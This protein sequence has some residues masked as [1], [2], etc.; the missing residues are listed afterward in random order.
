MEAVWFVL[1]M[2]G[3][4]YGLFAAAWL[5]VLVSTDAFG[6]GGLRPR[7][8]LWIGLLTALFW[9]V[10]HGPGPISLDAALGTQRTGARWAL[11]ALMFFARAVPPFWPRSCRAWG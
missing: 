7:L 2:V 1:K 5:Y 9:L 10:E 8:P 6:W 11:A 4:W 3:L